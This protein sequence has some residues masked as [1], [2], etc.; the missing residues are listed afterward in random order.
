LSACGRRRRPRAARARAARA[1][2]RVA[3]APP[4]AVR[5]QP[6]LRTL[7][8]C[9]KMVAQRRLKTAAAVHLVRSLV[10]ACSFLVRSGARISGFHIDYEQCSGQLSPTSSR[11][12][13]TAHCHTFLTFLTNLSTTLGRQS[14]GLP[15]TRLQLA[16]DAGTWM[17]CSQPGPKCFFPEFRG[18]T[19]SV[20]RHVIDVA[21]SIQLMDYS[22][23]PTDVMARALPFLRYADSI[24]KKRSIVVGLALLPYPGTQT[25]WQCKDEAALAALMAALQGN[26]SR[27]ASFRGFAVFNSR[28]WVQ[29]SR[30]APAPASTAYLPTAVWGIGEDNTVALNSTKAAAWL[31]WAKTRRITTAFACP[32]CSNTD[33]IPIPGIEGSD[34]DAKKFCQFIA[35]ADQHGMDLMLNTNGWAPGRRGW[36]SFDFAFVHNCT[37]SLQL[38]ALS[39]TT[40]LTGHPS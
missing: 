11:A 13:Q 25:W 9:E 17:A 5:S 4:R 22:Q 7:S 31:A 38:L 8:L 30:H 40:A 19:Q 32:H 26:L 15:G 36:D 16:V 12:S 27:H 14:I 3:V 24:G 29:S 37:L 23:S 39:A 34:A 21:D 6:P 2:A 1:A 33:L 20:A 18:K 35:L 28:S 10:V